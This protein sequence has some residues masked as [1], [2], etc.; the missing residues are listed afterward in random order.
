MSCDLLAFGVTAPLELGDHR[1]EVLDVLVV[2]EMQT[3]L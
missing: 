3:T 1:L 2:R